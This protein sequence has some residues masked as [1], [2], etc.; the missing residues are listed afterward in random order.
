MADVLDKEPR[1]QATFPVA[2]DVFVGR[3]TIE[4]ILNRGGF[5]CVYKAMQNDLGR[6]V[7]IKVLRPATRVGFNDDKS[8]AD[9]RLD[10]VSKRFEREAQL[11]SQLRDPHTVLMYEYGQTPDGLLYMVLEF[12]NGQALSDVIAEE[13]AVT[14]TRAVNIV[15]QALSSLEE[16]HARGVLHR[17]IKPPNIM[18][19][20]HMGRRDQIKVLDF[21]LAKSMDDPVFNADNPDLTDDEVLIGTPRYMSPEQ[22]RG[23]RLAPSTDIYSLGLVFYELLVGEKAV[24]AKSTMNTLARHINEVPIRLPDELEVEPSLRRIVNQMIEK[25]VSKRYAS[26]SAIMQDLENYKVEPSVDYLDYE[27]LIEYELEEI[28]VEVVAPPGDNRKRVAIV[29]LIV[30][31]CLAI[32]FMIFGDNTEPEAPTEVA[33][34]ANIKVTEPTQPA[35]LEAAAVTAPEDLLDSEPSAELDPPVDAPIIELEK[36]A[37]EITVKP[38]DLDVEKKVRTPR[39]TNT[40]KK[41]RKPNLSTLP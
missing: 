35:N 29:I 38:S 32:G 7:A 18:L 2:G 3:F 27:S 41:I 13:G 12:I 17:D 23:H 34:E 39:P 19:Y 25:D 22:I 8:A 1:E 6:P 14:P 37:E 28:S 40:S 33:N 30:F 4:S 31:F 15:L 21:G 20:S 36:P 26:A 10:I 5:G 16:A 9:R 11:V 24:M